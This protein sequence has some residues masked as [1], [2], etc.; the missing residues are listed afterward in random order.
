M[1]QHPIPL[2][3]H[4]HGA[5]QCC[6]DP[7]ALL[8]KGTARGQ[9]WPSPGP[10]HEPCSLLCVA[11]GQAAELHGLLDDGEVLVERQGNLCVAVLPRH[12]AGKSHPRLVTRAGM[13]PGCSPGF[14][15][16]EEGRTREQ[17]QCP[18]GTGGSQPTPCRFVQSRRGG[19]HSQGQPRGWGHCCKHPPTPAWQLWNPRAVPGRSA[20]PWA[21]RAGG[22]VVARAVCAAHVVAVGNPKVVVK[23]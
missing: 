1:G 7:G 8:A 22:Q 20:V 4:Q 18:H 11:P 14:H 2:A 5:E 12:P 17:C 13:E 23:A 16:A 6:S 9:W 21:G 15:K 3:L 10:L 19:D